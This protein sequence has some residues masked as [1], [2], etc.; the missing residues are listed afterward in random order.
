MEYDVTGNGSGSYTCDAYE[1]EENL[2]HNLDLLKDAAEFQMNMMIM[3]FWKNK[4]VKMDLKNEFEKN[5]KKIIENLKSGN[6]IIIKQKKEDY[7]IY[8][9]SIKKL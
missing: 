8:I 2:C 6:D 1:A 3:I 7:K 9:N 5:Y 4:E